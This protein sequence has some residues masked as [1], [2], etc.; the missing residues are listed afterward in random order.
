MGQ[1]DNTLKRVTNTQYL[2][3]KVGRTNTGIKGVEHP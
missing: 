2:R 3:D 1:A